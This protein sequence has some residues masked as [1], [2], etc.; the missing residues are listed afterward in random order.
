MKLTADTFRTLYLEHGQRAQGFFLRMTGFDRELAR[1]LTQDLFMR[2]WTSRES[3]DSGRSFRT[4]MFSIAY[5]MLKNE[6]RRRMTV[7]EYMENAD[8]N[9]PVT[10]TDHLEQEQ[11]DRILRSAI[12]HLPEPQKVVFLLRYEEEL[13]LTEIARICNIPE[14]TVKSRLFTALTA[15]RNY[16][17]NNE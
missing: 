14:G 9:E 12:G 13:T 8:K 2:L 16:F 4:W 10:E 11:R 5:N 17:K 6:Y 7:M 3:Y 1:D 15:V